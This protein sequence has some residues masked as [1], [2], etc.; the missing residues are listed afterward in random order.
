VAHCTAFLISSLSTGIT[1]EVLH[2]DAGAH[3]VR[4]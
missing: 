2:V 1:G 4:T 3:A